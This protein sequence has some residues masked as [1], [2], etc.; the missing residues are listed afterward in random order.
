MA[1]AEGRQPYYNSDATR[2]VVLSAANRV[3]ASAAA[4][5]AAKS[6]RDSPPAVSCCLL[7]PQLRC[8]RVVATAC[9]VAESD[10]GADAGL[11]DLLLELWGGGTLS[12]CVAVLEP[13]RLA[14]DAAAAMQ[15]GAGFSGA[16]A[17]AAAGGKA[18]RRVREF[19]GK[20]TSS[21]LQGSA[22]ASCDGWLQLA[23]R[24]SRSVL[25]QLCQRTRLEALALLRVA[26]RCGGK[27][28]SLLT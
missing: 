18:A 21:E 2:R 7:W 11:D 9:E 4:A 1:A 27:G 16:D 12:A 3:T 26:M 5:T 23:G 15:R 17:A 28:R 22:Y 8:I 20:D 25:Q 14:R 10:L 19:S 13:G 24:S 6:S